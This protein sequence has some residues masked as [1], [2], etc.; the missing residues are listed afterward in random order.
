M[1]EKPPIKVREVAASSSLR[2]SI[3]VAQASILTSF[4]SRS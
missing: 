4:P 1:Q 2:L 3:C